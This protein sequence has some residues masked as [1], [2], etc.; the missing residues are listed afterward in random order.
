MPSQ[1]S[2]SRAAVRL[3]SMRTSVS[4]RRGRKSQPFWWV[5]FRKRPRRKHGYYSI[6]KGLNR[7]GWWSM[8]R[9][10]SWGWISPC[11]V[12]F[13]VRVEL[14]SVLIQLPVGQLASSYSPSDLF[15]QPSSTDYGPQAH[16]CIA[17]VHWWS[18]KI[19][20]H[21]FLAQSDDTDRG[22]SKFRSQCRSIINS[23]CRPQPEFLFRLF[24]S[25]SLWIDM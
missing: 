16:W 21:S 7:R 10:V 20:R 19:C 13:T 9:L 8:W 2:Q 18:E 25:L 3:T 14:Q 1:G 12:G 23:K 22:Y 17:D 24:M 11:S 15:S 5:N 6:H 4:P